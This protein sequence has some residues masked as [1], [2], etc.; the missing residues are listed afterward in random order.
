MFLVSLKPCE[1]DAGPIRVTLSRT[2]GSATQRT[3]RRRCPPGHSPRLCSEP[4]EPP[5]H[6]RGS[7]TVAK[8]WRLEFGPFE[9]WGVGRVWMTCLMWPSIEVDILA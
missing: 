5:D 8:S 3:G 4:A 1:V 7:C 2:A 6:H 9:Y